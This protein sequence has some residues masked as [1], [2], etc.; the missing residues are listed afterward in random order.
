ML[1]GQR[2]VPL[3][4][5]PAPG[6][7]PRPPSSCR[8]L[9]TIWSSQLTSVCWIRAPPEPGC[10]GFGCFYF[11]C[12][13]KSLPSAF[14][15]SEV[16]EERACSNTSH[17]EP[18]SAA[19]GIAPKRPGAK[20]A[21]YYSVKKAKLCLAALIMHIQSTPLLSSTY[22]PDLTRQAGSEST[23]II[24]GTTPLPSVAS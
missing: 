23:K 17:A 12:S 13:Q 22:R 3:H 10:P 9:C 24:P 19:A 18:G 14:G 20:N 2:F 7:S 5:P 6:S 21:F 11:S 15:L 16:G 4:L 1:L 8:T